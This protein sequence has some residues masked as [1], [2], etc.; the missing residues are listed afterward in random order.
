MSYRG[1][2]FSLCAVLCSLKYASSDTYVLYNTKAATSDLDWTL[3]PPYNGWEELSGLDVDGNTIRSYQVCNTE[4]PSQDNWARSPYIDAKSAKRVYIDIEFSVMKC[5]DCRETFTLYYYPSSANVASSTFPPWREN[6][7]IKIDTVAASERFDSDNAGPSG[8]NKKTLVI[9]PLQRPGFY[10]AAQDQ[11]ACMSLMSLKLYYHYCPEITYN[12]AYFPKTVA[13]GQVASLIPVDGKCVSNAIYSGTEVPKYRCNSNGDWKVPTGQCQCRAGYT[14]SKD[15]TS[16]KA[17]PVGYYKSTSGN[18]ACTPCPAHSRAH[19]TAATNCIC[20]PGYHRAATDSPEESCT[21]PPSGPSDLTYD[22]NKTVVQINWL[23]PVR[24]GNRDDIYYSVSCKQCDES[25]E[26][27]VPCP[28]SVNYEPSQR[29]HVTSHSM[30]VRDLQPFSYYVIKVA[31]HNGVSSVSKTPAAFEQ[32]EFSTSEAV[33]S[34]VLDLTSVRN[35][36]RSLTLQWKPPQRSNGRIIEYEVQVKATDSNGI[37]TILTPFTTEGSVRNITIDGLKS[38]T[39]YEARVRARTAAGFGQFSQPFSYYTPQEAPPTNAPIKSGDST[40]IIAGIVAGVVVLLIIIAVVI[41]IRRR[42]ASRLDAANARANNKLASDGS[43]AELLGRNGYGG[44]PASRSARKTYV[45]YRDPH[46]GVKEIAREIDV[47]R[48]KI[49]RVIGRGEFGEVCRGKLM[50]GKNSTTVAVKRLQHG[51]SLIDQ[52]NFLREACTIAQ[53][54]DPNIVQFKGVVTKS[55]PAMIITEFM[56]NGSL[57]KF[58]QKKKGQLTVIQLIEILKGIASG[59]RY[60]SNMKYVHR[61]LAAR[62]ILVNS[63]LV[64]KVSDFG[65]SRT[66][67]NDPHATYTTQGGK[68]ALRWTAP[69]CIR[70]RQFTSLSDVWSYGIVMWEVMSYG[71]KPYWDMSN[72]DVSEVIEDGYRL[73]AP[74]D[75]PAALHNLMLMCWSFEPRRRPNFSDIF[76]Q[77]GSFIRQPN[78]LQSEA[79]VDNSAPLLNPDS[80][81]TLQDVSNLEEWLDMVKLGRYRRSFYAHGINDLES[82]AHITASDLERLEIA[83]PAHRSR[84]ESGLDT[85]RRHLSSSEHS[86]VAVP[87]MSNTMRLASDVS[88]APSSANRSFTLPSQQQQQ[89]QL[90]RDPSVALV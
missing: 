4:E 68:I 77:L 1:Y 2:L 6:P 47:T 43:T 83:S 85:L 70:Y 41:L 44:T 16:C 31:S 55:M 89:R 67:E 65:L 58:L 63:E 26:R 15:R 23:P 37:V 5:P 84:L 56:D 72:D 73:P 33:P 86:P 75:C 53:F 19:S 9:G 42:R 10:I 71:E 60:L 82:L 17:C 25:F 27:C 54:Y 18:H 22:I 57:D 11:G 20:T 13:G 35:Q 87:G 39:T 51:A 40:G 48:I 32:I 76:A 12:L 64:C 28:S 62:N 46:K 3:Q 61:D 14:P 7:F 24:T 66:L 50:D 88:P 49:E 38:E 21:K 90:S 59:M 78:Q 81:T 36:L 29:H 45:D 34:A 52:T 8:I 74:V 69:E 30:I 80:P 79:L